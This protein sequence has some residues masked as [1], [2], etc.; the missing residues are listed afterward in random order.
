MQREASEKKATLAK[1]EQSSSK[2]SVTL[3]RPLERF[4][5]GSHWNTKKFAANRSSG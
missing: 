2:L 1:E 5:H 3:R 4:V